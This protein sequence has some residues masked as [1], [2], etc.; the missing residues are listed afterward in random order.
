MANKKSFQAP[1]PAVQVRPRSSPELFPPFP[2]LAP[3]LAEIYY[4]D[5]DGKPMSDNFWQSETMH[6]HYGML[7]T[8]YMDDPNTLVALALPLYYTEGEP[9]DVVAPG[10]FVS[11]GVPKR[12]RHWYKVWEEGKV[13]DFAL[14]VSTEQSAE[15]N[16][17]RNLETYA[18]IGIPEYCAYDPQGGLHSP[19]LQMFRLAG[20]EVGSYDRVKVGKNPDGSL[21]V[22]SESLGLELR[23]E[24]DRLRLWDPATQQYLLEHLEERAGHLEEHAR[25]LKE[26][27]RRLKARA[28]RFKERAG[29]IRERA[30]RMREHARLIAAERRLREL[31]VEVAEHKERL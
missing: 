30:G 7:S 9:A 12:H 10:L 14:E 5:S 2:E 17:G 22:P 25:R 15:E 26:Y 31:E 21:A 11:H 4:P 24:D 20:G 18:R 6:A 27:A 13:P 1:P 19:R 16:L 28:G 3:E 23:F 29:R 8:R